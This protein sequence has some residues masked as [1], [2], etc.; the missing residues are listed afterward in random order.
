MLHPFKCHILLYTS[1][2]C[3]F[4]INGLCQLNLSRPNVLPCIPF[5]VLLSVLFSLSVTFCVFLSPTS[6][7]FTSSTLVFLV[8]P[9][10][11]TA[12]SCFSASAARWAWYQFLWCNN[13]Q[14]LWYNSH[15]VPV[16]PRPPAPTLLESLLLPSCSCHQLLCCSKL[17]SP[18]CNVYWISCCSGPW[19]QSTPFLC[20]QTGPSTAFC[21]MLLKPTATVSSGLACGQTLASILPQAVYLGVPPISAS[22]LIPGRSLSSITSAIYQSSFVTSKTSCDCFVYLLWLIPAFDARQAWHPI[23]PVFFLY[24]IDISSASVSA[25]G[26]Y[27]SSSSLS[28]GYSWHWIYSL[29]ASNSGWTDIH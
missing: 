25:S 22:V 18:S 26:S 20:L 5:W 23:N 13:F 21:Q 9:W 14:S 17:F 15:Q 3:S 2:F 27:P 11:G 1:C 19:F 4:P 24:W 10:Q 16:L 7:L 28:K 29:L 6:P 12:D 8:K